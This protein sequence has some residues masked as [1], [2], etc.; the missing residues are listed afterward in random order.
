MLGLRLQGRRSLGRHRLAAQAF[1]CRLATAAKEE[2]SRQQPSAHELLRSAGELCQGE[3]LERAWDLAEPFGGSRPPKDSLALLVA[4]A[5]GEEGGLERARRLCLR[6][7]ALEGRHAVPISVWQSLVAAHARAG[8]ADA[9]FGML[10]SLE[11][12]DGAGAVPAPV[13]EALICG[14][15]ESRNLPAAFDAFRRLKTWTLAEPGPALC[16]AMVRACGIVGDVEQASSIYDGF[17]ARQPPTPELRAELIVALAGRRRTA[18]EAFRLAGEAQRHGDPLPPRLVGALAA[19]CARGGLAEEARRLLRRLRAAGAA[20]DTRAKAD[21]IR[22]FGA[23]AAR[24]SGEADSERERL[25]AH[26]WRILREA[27]G[28]RGGVP[29]EVFNALV[30]AYC[31]CGLPEHAEAVLG[32]GQELGCAPDEESFAIVLE[33]LRPEPRRFRALWGR[34]L[35][36]TAA[37]PTPAM[38]RMALEV[39]AEAEDARWAV[40]LLELLFAAKAAPSATAMGALRGLPLGPTATAVRQLLRALEQQGLAPREAEG[41]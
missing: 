31:A 5:A 9:A 36:N 12:P 4:A 14:L 24:C 16:A 26:A 32:M 8:D 3:A 33:A 25:L 11:S 19:A 6:L 18:R 22:A 39:A 20:P 38:L 1:R 30:E 27:P 7:L 40:S 21:L 29:T 17:A 15:V 41:G 10:G 13:L 2:A 35:G 34:L 37:Q 23:A 28:P